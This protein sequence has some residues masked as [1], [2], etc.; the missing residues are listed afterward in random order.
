[1]SFLKARCSSRSFHAVALAGWIRRARH[2][3]RKK[4][5]RKAYK[6]FLVKRKG[7]RPLRRPRRRCEDN[8]KINLNETEWE[9]ADW[10]HV[11]QDRGR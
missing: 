1:V 8:I 4:G 5:I 6:M 9:G 7:K 11:A 10:I 2:V 3:A